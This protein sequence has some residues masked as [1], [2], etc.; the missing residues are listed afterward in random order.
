MIEQPVNQHTG[1]HWSLSR[2]PPR[3]KDNSISVR[4]GCPDWTKCVERIAIDVYVMSAKEI[5]GKMV[6]EYKGFYDIGVIRCSVL[7]F[8]YDSLRLKSL[9]LPKE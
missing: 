9:E 8:Q 5:N 2:K 7:K 1:P 6:R 3:K 4:I